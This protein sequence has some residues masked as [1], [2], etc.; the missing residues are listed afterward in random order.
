[1]I[2][3]ISVLKLYYICCP[4]SNIEYNV[5]QRKQSQCYHINFGRQRLHF[6][7]SSSCQLSIY[8]Y[9]FTCC[10]P[11]FPLQ[12]HYSCK[13]NHGS[14]NKAE[15]YQQI[16][17]K[18]IYVITIRIVALHWF[19]NIIDIKYFQYHNLQPKMKNILFLFNY[20]YH[21]IDEEID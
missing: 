14:H 17:S 9:F 7:W 8:C 3:F 4:M 13:L 16:Y 20:T 12:H 19:W 5:T 18:A 15:G 21:V 6:K 10:K 1:M 2:R 11:I